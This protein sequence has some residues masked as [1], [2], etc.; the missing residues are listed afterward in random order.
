MVNFIIPRYETN[1]I[2]NNPGWSL[3]YGR[4][5]VG[6]TFLI[7]NFIKYDVYFSVRIDRSV[8]CKGFIVNE[9]S[10]LNAFKNSVTDLLQKDKTVVIDEFQ[11]LPFRVIEDI[12]KIHPKGKLILSGSSLRVSKSLLGQNSPL[13]GLLRPFKIGLVHPTNIIKF[14]SNKLEAEEIINI[15][16]F[17]RDPWTIPFYSKRGFLESITQMLPFVVPG[18]IGEIFRE[19]QRELTQTYSSILSLIGQGYTDHREIANI[20]YSRSMISS[21]A[22]SSVLPY[23]KNMHSMGLLDKVKVFG[24]SK[25][26]YIMPSF[27]MKLYYYLQS[28]YNIT[29][30]EFK[31]AEVKP[32]VLHLLNLAIEDTVADIF[33]GFL[34]GRKEIFKTS[35][36]ELD[37]LITVRNKHALVGEVKWGKLTKKDVG[38]FLEKVKNFDCKKVIITKKKLDTDE[39]EILTPVELIKYSQ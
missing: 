4:R 37:I 10:D 29:D 7:E 24:A 34:S 21:S 5:K 28:R 8:F 13:L 12:S 31:F 6:K 35:E 39:V 2:N 14:L 20:L 33:T 38:R 30:R 26:K 23:M 3:I 18:L 11:R 32:T 1:A 27:I 19:D 15:A 25:E 9:L 16:P 36:K 17:F 22:S